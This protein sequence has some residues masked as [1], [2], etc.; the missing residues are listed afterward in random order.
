VTTQEKK[1]GE[2]KDITRFCG[3]EVTFETGT[4]SSYVQLW[5]DPIDPTQELPTFPKDSVRKVT[6]LTKHYVGFRND[7]IY[8]HKGAVARVEMNRLLHTPMTN[9]DTTHLE[10]H[11]E[12]QI[13]A[14]SIRTLREIYTKV[15]SGKLK[16]SEDWGGIVKPP[17]LEEVLGMF[18]L[19]G[20]RAGGVGSPGNMN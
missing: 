1:Y 11:Q 12:I 20:A 5:G 14:G 16:P 13:S 8:R 2:M 17:T 19:A 3:H 10:E 4:E 6:F 9:G 7:G 18:S 15:R